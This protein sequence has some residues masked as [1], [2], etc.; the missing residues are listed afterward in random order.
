[1][2]GGLVIRNGSSN[3]IIRNITFWDAHGSTSN[4]TGK[5]GY[6]DAKASATAL[7]VENNPGGSGIWVDHCTFTDGTCVDLSRN[8]NH[9]GAF[10]IK[11]GRYITVSWCEFTNHDKV[12]L[13]GSN[14]HTTGAIT[15]LSP[16]ERQI[17]LHHNYFHGTTQRMPRTRGTQMH[18]YNNYYNNIG[19]AENGGA[20]MG[21]GY[22]AQF[23]VE[24]N[25]FGSK[26]GSKNF[27]WMDTSA[28]PAKVFYTGNNKADNDTGWYGRASDSVKPWTPAYTYAPEPYSGLPAS[29][30]AAAGPTLNLGN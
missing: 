22:N 21:P 9:D 6:G 5:S 26:A 29:V 7:Q 12:M 16:T 13:V 25:Y 8:Y 10:D 2:F 11:Y 1:M 24:N 14:D 3:I 27:E 28:Y 15:Y 18:V 20:F 19:T 23:I 4:D 30:P 17:T